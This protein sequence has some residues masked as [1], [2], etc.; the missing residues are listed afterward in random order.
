MGA[1]TAKPS[2]DLGAVPE[3]QRL[4]RSPKQEEQAWLLDM[5]KEGVRANC[6]YQLLARARA[7]K[8]LLSHYNSNMSNQSN[9]AALLEVVA[10][11]VATN[12]GCVDLVAKQG[13]LPWLTLV[14]RQSQGSRV[15]SK[16]I[17]MWKLLGQD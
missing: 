5:L 7:S 1:L 16:A 15:T 8:L 10:A 11:M 13:L 12:F 9:D 14:V 2:L 6:D 17:S 4:H 3:F